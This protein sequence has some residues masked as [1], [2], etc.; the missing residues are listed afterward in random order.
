MLLILFVL[1]V[2]LSYGCITEGG[3]CSS[4][5]ACCTRPC[6]VALCN[7]MQHNRTKTCHYLNTQC[8]INGYVCDHHTGACVSDIAAPTIQENVD[9]TILQTVAPLPPAPKTWAIVLGVS[10]CVAVFVIVCM[11]IYIYMSK[12]GT[13]YRGRLYTKKY[14]G[15]V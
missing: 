14:K 3:R 8:F 2:S 7:R 13:Q 10:L 1:F 5:I 6:Y 9:D 15:N 11:C 12:T 4:S